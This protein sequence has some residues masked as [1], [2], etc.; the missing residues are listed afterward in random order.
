MAQNK[1]RQ[2]ARLQ[3]LTPSKK[4]ASSKVP[5]GQNGSGRPFGSGNTPG[6]RNRVGGRATGQAPRFK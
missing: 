5:I 4:K 3:G 1:Q 6:E 2:M